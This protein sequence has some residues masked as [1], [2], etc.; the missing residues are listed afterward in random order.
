M[1]YIITNENNEVTDIVDGDVEGGIPVIGQLANAVIGSVVIDG[2]LQPDEFLIIKNGVVTDIVGREVAGGVPLTGGLA[3][4]VIGSR[5]IDG[6]IQPD[7]FL[8]IDENGEVTDIVGREAGVGIPVIG[9]LTNAKIGSRIKNG[10]LRNDVYLR[11]ENG[12]VTNRVSGGAEGYVK[13]TGKLFHA[14]IG[15]R[16]ENGEIIPSQEELEQR[17]ANLWLISF[18]AYQVKKNLRISYVAYISAENRRGVKTPVTEAKL[19]ALSL[20]MADDWRELKESA[21]DGYGVHADSSL[22]I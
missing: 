13:A 19:K 17:K 6:V 9:P 21:P 20:E 16:I 11:I 4:A 15:S 2:V 7:K 8:I 10:V 1:R 5:I 3:N 22:I 12:F 14:G 18:N